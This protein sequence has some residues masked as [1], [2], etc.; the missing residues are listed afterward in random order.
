LATELKPTVLADTTA[1]AL[2]ARDETF[3]PIAR[4]LRFKDDA[5][6][7]LHANAN[8]FGPAASIDSRDIGRVL[9]LDE[10]VE[11]AMSGRHMA[12]LSSDAATFGG[13][14]QSGLEKTIRAKELLAIRN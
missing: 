1:D 10:A 4:R 2:C 11:V 13:V 7:W 12:R 9:W 6:L 3:G 14:K 5:E 8:E